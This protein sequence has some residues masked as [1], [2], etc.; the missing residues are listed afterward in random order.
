M[1]RRKNQKKVN[2]VSERRR[3]LC[4]NKQIALKNKYR[5]PKKNQHIMVC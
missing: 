3:E 5:R 4:K 1:K 2:D